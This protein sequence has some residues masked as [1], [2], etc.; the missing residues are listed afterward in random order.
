MRIYLI[1]TLA[2]LMCDEGLRSGSEVAV[3][4]DYPN[5]AKFSLWFL[6]KDTTFSN[7]DSA[8]MT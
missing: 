2:D 6:L 4:S 1:T 8:L 3:F 5:S 7:E